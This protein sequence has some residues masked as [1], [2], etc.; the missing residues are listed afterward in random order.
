V[1]RARLTP[2]TAALAEGFDAVCP[3]VNDQ[4][5]AA[6]IS[7][8]AASGSRLLTLRSA[9]FNHVDLRA[10]QAPAL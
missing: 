1:V 3:F 7:L 10:P 4:L 8:L 2:H 5:S 6:V 9:G